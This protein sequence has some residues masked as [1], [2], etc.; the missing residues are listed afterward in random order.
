MRDRQFQQGRAGGLDRLARG[1][2]GDGGLV[3]G[4]G[5]QDGAFGVAFC[6]LAEQLVEQRRVDHHHGEQV[7]RERQRVGAEAEAVR[8]DAAVAQR[9]RH[10]PG[11]RPSVVVDGGA[12]AAVVLVDAEQFLGELAEHAAPQVEVVRLVPRG[13][14]GRLEDP[15]GD[16]LVHAAGVADPRRIPPVQ[17]ERRGARRAVMAQGQRAG[18]DGSR[19]CG[20][21]PRVS[22]GVAQRLAPGGSQGGRPPLARR[23]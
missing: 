2:L 4:A 13:L 14:A 21:V 7:K 15:D 10:R 23:S 19:A 12:L 9:V 22:D 11:E 6:Q 18:G 17:R 3:E 5:L 20:R 8:A 1:Q 16:H